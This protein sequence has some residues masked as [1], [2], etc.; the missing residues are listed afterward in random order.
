MSI[1]IIKAISALF[2]VAAMLYCILLLIKKYSPKIIGKGFIT[3]DDIKI[4]SS[5]YLDSNN[6]II[7]IGHKNK[8]Y[9]I[10]LGKNNNILLDKYENI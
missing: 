5:K 1:F 3:S 7:S 9:L 8:G 4:E 2:G 6:R 10:L